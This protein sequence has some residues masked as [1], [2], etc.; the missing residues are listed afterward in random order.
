MVLQIQGGAKLGLQ[1]W[2]QEWS[3]F[4][5]YYLL[6][7]VLFFH[8]NNCRPT[9]ASPIYSHDML[10]SQHTWK[11]SKINLDISNITNLQFENIKPFY[12][13][14]QLSYSGLLNCRDID[15]AFS[16]QSCVNERKV[17]PSL[18]VPHGKEES[19]ERISQINELNQLRKIAY[20]VLSCKFILF[21]S[22]ARSWNNETYLTMFN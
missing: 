19:P 12:Y 22:I 15:R 10:C 13:I 14:S 2:V 5:Y 21:I 7:I 1:L 18:K 6:I 17:R 8:G 3:L 16:L 9:F 4:L 11:G 20:C